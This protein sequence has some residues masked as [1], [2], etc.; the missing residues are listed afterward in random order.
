MFYA[1]K[2][3]WKSEPLVRMVWDKVRSITD[4]CKRTRDRKQISLDLVSVGDVAFGDDSCND[5][6]W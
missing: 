6:R 4:G 2:A 5:F 1:V 3:G